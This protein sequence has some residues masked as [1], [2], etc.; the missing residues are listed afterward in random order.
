[1]NK[2]IQAKEI[3]FALQLFVDRI[4]ETEN[5]IGGK[6]DFSKNEK[7]DL[8]TAIS[9]LKNDLKIA[10][11]RQTV[12]IG[13]R[14]PNELEA[15]YFYYATCD[16]ELRL[17]MINLSRNP[18]TNMWRSRLDDARDEILNRIRQLEDQYLKNN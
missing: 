10:A 14:D 7:D 11:N 18:I 13:K 3:V 4:I 6:A 8:K 17:Q 16:A 15:N 12:Q 2:Q 5:L 1:M 9:S